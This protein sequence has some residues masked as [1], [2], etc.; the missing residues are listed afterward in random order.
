MP[1]PRSWWTRPAVVYTIQV[2]V[3]MCVAYPALLLGSSAVRP[4]VSS[5]LL[6]AAVSVVPAI[7]V[8]LVGVA[9]ARFLRQADEL[10]R[11]IQLQAMTASLFAVM[12]VALTA[13]F[14]EVG[15]ARPLTAWVYVI[16]GGGVWVLAIAL[17]QLR[18][19]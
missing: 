14:L 12:G 5:N 2:L 1:S 16:V 15:G 19:R 17:L 11:R 13:G 3:L 9:M 7:P 10:Q 8:L 4:Y 18:Y 6:R